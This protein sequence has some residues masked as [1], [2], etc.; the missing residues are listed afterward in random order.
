MLQDYWSSE[1]EGYLFKALEESR[2]CSARTQVYLSKT[3][4]RSLQGSI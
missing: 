1:D 2:E 3:K 4:L